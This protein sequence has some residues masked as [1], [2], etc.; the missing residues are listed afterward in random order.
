MVKIAS[1]IRYKP[2]N[3]TRIAYTHSLWIVMRGIYRHYTTL[4]STFT[5]LVYAGATVL[6]I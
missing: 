3:L 1:K 5:I 2:Q 4:V 6:C